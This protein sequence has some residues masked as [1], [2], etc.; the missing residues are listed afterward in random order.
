MIF[1]RLLNTKFFDINKNVN[2]HS[3][4]STCA[5]T[6]KGYDQQNPLSCDNFKIFSALL[7]LA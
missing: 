5:T 4:L 1:K 6:T 3:A 2:G 7:I